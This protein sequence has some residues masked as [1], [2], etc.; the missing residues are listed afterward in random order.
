MKR[1]PGFFLTTLI[2]T[3]AISQGLK[4]QDSRANQVLSVTP[5]DIALVDSLLDDIGIV[6]PQGNIPRAR[7][8]MG[9]DVDLYQPQPGR[10]ILFIEVCARR[11]SETAFISRRRYIDLRSGHQRKVLIVVMRYYDAGSVS[12]CEFWV[13][14]GFER[15]ENPSGVFR[16]FVESECGDAHTR[17]ERRLEALAN[18][19]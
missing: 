7:S 3:T 1:L 6:M 15:G 5:A 10:I 16:T 18:L 19:P 14:Q 4:A 13:D 17:F 2:F 11:I 8:F 12:A 9:C